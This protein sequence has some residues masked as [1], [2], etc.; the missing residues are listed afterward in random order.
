MAPRSS[1]SLLQDV[2]GA[3]ALGIVFGSM[4]YLMT[5]PGVKDVVMD[6]HLMRYHLQGHA[7]G[8]QGRLLSAC[9]FTV[10]WGVLVAGGV[11]RLWASAVGGILYG[12]VLGTVLSILAS[13]LGATILF[14]AGSTFLSGMVERR[15][16]QVVL[17]LRERFRKNSFW[18][19][20][21]MRLFPLANS[22]VV[23]LACG[24]AGI[25]FR[26]YFLAS[27]IGFVPMAAV[28][29]TYG[30]GGV[31]GNLTQVVLAT[32]L[33][34]LSFFLRR[35]IDMVRRPDAGSYGVPNGPD[36]KETIS[37]HRK[38]SA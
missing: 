20:L 18:W 22:T 35:V 25:P 15:L 32:I 19:V 2:L 4:A 9:A 7:L 21:Y 13:L 28:F 29:A 6:V 23:S 14:F 37:S 38:P 33:L 31:K 30:S 26:D 8:W 34:I 10:L 16:G 36:S 17:S 24:G 11:P 5:R 3:A 27:L 12:A 1:R